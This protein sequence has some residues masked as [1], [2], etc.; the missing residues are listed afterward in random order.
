VLRGCQDSRVYIYPWRGADRA[1]DVH[2]WVR[3]DQADLDV[4]SHDA[5][6]A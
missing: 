6:A 5:V 3:A 1:A 4:A 2:S